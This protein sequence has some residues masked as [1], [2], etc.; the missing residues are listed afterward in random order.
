MAHAVVAR[1]PR[2]PFVERTQIEHHVS[3]MTVTAG[4]DVTLGTLQAL[5]AQQR[6]WLPVDGDDAETLGAL[7][8]RNSTG[9][10]RL[11]YG[12]WRDMLLGAQFTD[13]ASGLVTVGGRVVKNVAGYDVTKFLVGSHGLIGT[14]VT[15][16][17]RCYLRPAGAILARFAPDVA[18]LSSLL[19]TDLCPQYALLTRDSL[20]CGYLGDDATLA[21]YD[22]HLH[23]LSDARQ[24]DRVP[25]DQDVDLRRLQW[26][27][28]KRFRASV[29]STNI[30][31]FV[32]DA[33]LERW[34]AD[35][36]FGI[37]VGSDRV[38]PERVNAIAKSLGGWAI[39][40]DDTGKPL[41][42]P[43][44]P[45]VRTIVDRLRKSFDPESKLA[46]LPH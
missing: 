14:P 40:F 27:Y 43:L 31:A 17:T 1:P 46:S 38:D 15:V 11:G 37:V 25:L 35:A 8:L 45:S 26:S 20:L 23:A 2:T 28:H 44:E 29:P 4:A 24:V 30:A 32:R 9:P 5:L 6:Q 34:G 41:N 18:R 36:C 33:K 13:G 19:P 12:A 10:L 7:V 3:D 39:G 22:K 16:T 21:F 42:M